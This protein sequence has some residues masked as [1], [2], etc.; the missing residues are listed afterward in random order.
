MNRKKFKKIAW[1]VQ[2]TGKK[3]KKK[4]NYSHEHEQYNE[5]MFFGKKEKKLKK[6][7]ALFIW[8]VQWIVK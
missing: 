7:V 6:I 2:W 4:S 5:P 8:T 3:W 1:V